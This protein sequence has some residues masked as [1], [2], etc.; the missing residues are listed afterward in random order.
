LAGKGVDV[1]INEK[2]IHGHQAREFRTIRKI[3]LRPDSSDVDKQFVPAGGTW[4]ADVCVMPL[5][6]QS[7]AKLM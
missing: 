3:R 5:T 7:T 1:D 2:E 4:A 6:T